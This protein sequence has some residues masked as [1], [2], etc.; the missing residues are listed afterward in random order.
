MADK[1]IA[2][3]LGWFLF[4]KPLCLSKWIFWRQDRATYPKHDQLCDSHI[5]EVR[6][7]ERKGKVCS[8]FHK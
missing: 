4:S 8:V 7:G 1:I 6:E 5:K 3:V 2:V